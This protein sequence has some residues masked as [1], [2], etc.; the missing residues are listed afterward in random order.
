MRA[1]FAVLLVLLT[2]FSVSCAMPDEAGINHHPPEESAPFESPSS[3]GAKEQ[4]DLPLGGDG[5]N[6]PDDAALFE[7]NGRDTQDGPAPPEP[8]HGVYIPKTNRPS[9][10]SSRS[11]AY[12]LF[13]YQGRV[14]RNTSLYRGDEAAAISG[15]IGEKV[16][17]ATGNTDGWYAQDES[18][19]RFPG[20]ARGD[21]YSVIGH[22]DWYRLCMKES[23]TDSDGN[24][25][26]RVWFFEHLD[27][28]G[29]TNGYDLFV[30]RNIMEIYNGEILS[31]NW[32]HVK[33]VR[34]TNWDSTHPSNYIYRDLA[35]ITD[36]EISM[37]LYEVLLGQFEYVYE[38][39]GNDFYQRNHQAH[40]Y[41]YMDDNTVV[42]L[43]LL[44]GGYVG[45][46]HL[47]WYFVK[48]PGEAFDLI[49]NAAR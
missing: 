6:V 9:T 34:H 30:F 11:I 32:S 10:N 46:G 12:T 22:D 18:A 2:L 47:A 35:G 7:N 42:E 44:E 41:I 39:A 26:E 49:F 20:T 14:Y 5:Q 31:R 24:R 29:M 37:F 15:L 4:D 3:G 21:V 45:Y 23:Y 43:R 13:L 19:E 48:I 25:T 8:S 1:K 27:D 16:G 17:Y 40:L 33:Y 36:E 38:T 28:Y